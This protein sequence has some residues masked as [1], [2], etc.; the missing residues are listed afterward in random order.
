MGC[1]Y[2][3][4]HISW[5]PDISFSG[6]AWSCRIFSVKGC[7]II[8]SSSISSC[9]HDA[10]DVGRTKFIKPKFL[11]DGGLVLG[12]EPFHPL[13]GI[14]FW[15]PKIE[16]LDIRAHLTAKPA[17]LIMERAPDDENSLLDRPVGFDPQ[18]AFT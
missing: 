18:E 4:S 9:A 17:G 15:H 5:R 8:V 6:V 16:V 14:V 12:I 13:V 1:T 11:T 2:T 10:R 7:M 3:P